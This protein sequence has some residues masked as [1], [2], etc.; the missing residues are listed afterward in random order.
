MNGL[1]VGL[2]V[3]AVHCG[4]T[5]DR[6]RMPFG[7]LCRTDPGIRQVVGFGDRFTVR[8]TFGGK[9]GAR[10][11]P[12]GPIGRTCATARRRGPLCQ[13]TL[14][15]FVNITNGTI[16]ALEVSHA[17]RHINPPFTFTILFKE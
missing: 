15:R 6:I 12:Q 14:G 10:R 16:T 11:C 13:I 17:M 7:V 5:A 4:K 3:H 2:S 8:G 1:S 9:F